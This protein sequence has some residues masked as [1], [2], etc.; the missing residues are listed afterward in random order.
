MSVA[1]K[2][3]DATIASQIIQRYDSKPELLVQILHGFLERFGF[4]SE[5]AVR[6][7]ASE[8]NI[9]RAD[10]HGVVHYYH[11]FRTTMPGK[12][13][14]KICQAEACQA[15][16]SRELTAHAEKKLG[17]EISN[18]TEDGQ[19]SLEPIYCLG[20][21]A[22]SPAVMVNNKVHSRVDADKLDKIIE[23]CGD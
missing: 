15:M 19:I 18:T 6:Q 10:V 3:Y 4:I 8:L 22:C 16:G 1:Y 20:L 9:S 11:D 7:L 14:I 12:H 17:V 5:S 13:I 21:C 23:A 2:E